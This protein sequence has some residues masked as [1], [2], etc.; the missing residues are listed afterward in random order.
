MLLSVLLR[1]LLVVDKRLC[2]E[3]FVLSRAC[4]LPVRQLLAQGRD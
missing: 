3:S 1:A 2:A 4:I